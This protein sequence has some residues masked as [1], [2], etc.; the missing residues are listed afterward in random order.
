MTGMPFLITPDWPA[1]ARVKACSSTRLGGCSVAPYAALNLGDHVGDDVSKVQHNR[2]WLQQHAGMPADPVWLNQ[3]HGVAVVQLPLGATTL[4]QAD[5]VLSAVAGQVCAVMT[6]DC[7][8]V[9]FCDKA[10]TQVAAVHAGWR[11]LHAGILEATIQHFKQPDQLMVWLGPAIGPTAF[12]VGPEVRQLF[13]QQHPESIAAF[14]PSQQG[15][16]LA[17]LYLLARLRLQAAGV[18]A[19]YGGDY[20]TYSQPDLFFSYRR[21]GQTGRMASCIWLE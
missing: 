20:C 17:N 19:I 8:P 11:G 18:S 9:L 2:Q 13:I 5:A 15:K 1:A 7:L 10:G 3:V 21:E 16:W 6:A 14:Q 4:V 12:E